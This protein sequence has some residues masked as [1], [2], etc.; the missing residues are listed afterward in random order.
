MMCEA[1]E[2]QLH[3][4]RVLQREAEAAVEEEEETRRKDGQDFWGS[5]RL[6]IPASRPSGWSASD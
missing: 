6:S 5:W 4:G 2:E 3:K 1:S